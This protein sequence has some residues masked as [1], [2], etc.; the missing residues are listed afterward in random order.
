VVATFHTSKSVKTKGLSSGGGR[1]TSPQETGPTMSEGTG[2]TEGF[3]EGET[4]ERKEDPYKQ[5]R[6]RRGRRINQRRNPA[7][8]VCKK[9]K[10]RKDLLWPGVLR[11]AGRTKVEGKKNSKTTA[12]YGAKV[13]GRV[14][15]NFEVGQRNKE[16]LSKS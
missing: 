11:N 2:V 4:D 6:R 15:P 3:F 16:R 5:S 1:V 8:Q 14:K 10:P 12:G 9:G 13:F 7:G